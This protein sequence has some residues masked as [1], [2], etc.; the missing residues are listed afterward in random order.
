MTFFSLD[1]SL[2]YLYSLSGI[3][4]IPIQFLVILSILNIKNNGN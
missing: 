2:S 1:E 3:K 4:Y